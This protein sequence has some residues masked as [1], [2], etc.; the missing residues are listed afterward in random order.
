MPFDSFCTSCRAA[1]F[2]KRFL[3]RKAPEGS[4][5]RFGLFR[6]LQ[7]AR[8][9]GG[10][11]LSCSLLAGGLL[12][13]SPGCFPKNAGDRAG[14]ADSKG[15]AAEAPEEK[16]AEKKAE[17]TAARTKRPLLINGGGASFPYI[18]YAR[19]FSDFRSMEPGAAFNYQSIG[20]GGGVRQFL[21]GTLDFGATDIPVSEK[22][23]P[24]G[25]RPEEIIHIP[26]ILGAVAVTYN[27]DGLKDKKLRFDGKTLTQI[28]TGRIK[29]WNDPA[30]KALNP[31]ADLPGKPFVVV[32]R[33]DGSGTTAS[34]AE[35]L[36]AAE[37]RFLKKY[38]KGK[39]VN[40]PVGIGGKGNE[41]IAG[42]LKKMDGAIAYIG[43]G[44]GAAQNLPMASIQNKEGVFVFPDE[45]SV[46]AAAKT[47]TAKAGQNKDYKI[48]LVNAAGKESYPISSFTYLIFSETMPLRKKQVFLLKFLRWAVLGKGQDLAAPLYFVPLPENVK[49]A[50]SQKLSRF[51]N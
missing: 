42:M 17:K 6:F 13:L 27:L 4:L 16:K 22:D 9:R 30:V 14:G 41:G 21:K 50:V 8:G 31:K 28:F 7:T 24:E 15:Q 12:L 26:T 35:Y 51:K 10:G 11:F 49:Q 29:K 40:W 37:N 2:R 23:L 38:G 39:S 25:R 45:K 46:K 36:G 34:F 33:A 32:Y 20:S 1:V 5:R 48:S 44:Y 43:A 18:L 19:W 47:A 3:F